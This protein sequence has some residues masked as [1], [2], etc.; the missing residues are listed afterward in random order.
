MENHITLADQAIHDDFIGDR[1]DCE[2][3]HAIS[4]DVTLL[5]F[6]LSQPVVSSGISEPIKQWIKSQAS[7]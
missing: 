6:F 2:L 7:G 4:S 5:G 3:E 1:I